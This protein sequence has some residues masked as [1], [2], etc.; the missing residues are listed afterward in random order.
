MK[1]GSGNYLNHDSVGPWLDDFVG[2][3]HGRQ[4]ALRAPGV[5]CACLQQLLHLFSNG[6]RKLFVVI[7]ELCHDAHQL[8]E[9]RV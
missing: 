7:R 1:R 5:V 3:R 2:S 6:F 8:K 4:A 9:I